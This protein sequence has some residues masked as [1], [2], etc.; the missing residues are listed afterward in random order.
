MKQHLFLVLFFITITFV[1]LSQVQSVQDDFEGN[2]TITS[3]YA[4]D[5]GMDL[6]FGN[7]YILGINTSSSVMRYNDYGG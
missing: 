6:M 7:P 4:D 3:W 1:G 2:G 5:C